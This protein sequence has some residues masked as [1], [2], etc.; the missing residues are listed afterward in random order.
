MC[1]GLG[2]RSSSLKSALPE[3]KKHGKFLIKGVPWYNKNIF[4][5]KKKLKKTLSPPLFPIIF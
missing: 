1:R 4:S 3:M 5:R 2:R